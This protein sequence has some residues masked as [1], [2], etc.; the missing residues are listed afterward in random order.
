MKI[1]F[2]SLGL[3]VCG[4]VRTIFELANGL[5]DRGHDISITVFGK[6][7]EHKWF[8]RPINASIHYADLTFIQR[9]FRK[10]FLNDLDYDY[11]EALA[12]MIPDCDVNVATHSFTAY[13]TAL[14]DK[15]KLFY[16]VQNY[17]PW[18]YEGE[19]LQNKA[20]LSYD[21]PLTKLVVS[22]W[23]QDKVG[24]IFVGNGVNLN[25]FRSTCKKSDYPM[26]LR[27][28]RGIYWKGEDI[29][30]DAIINCL[31]H[32]DF[33]TLVI[34]GNFTET[35]LI[36][37]YSSASAL[38]CAPK[39]EGFGLYVL[40]A[41]A[42]GCPV[43]T[44]KCVGIEEYAEHLNNAY[45]VS[46]NDPNA[47]ASALAEVLTAKA[48]SSRLIQGGLKTAQRFSFDKVVGRVEKAFLEEV[49]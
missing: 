4:G 49:S 2:N 40:E 24:G 13:P 6:K 29:V 46:K 11:A 35:E 25:L 38:M 10:L 14:S 47:L 31:E 21:L 48:L 45:V 26:V 28:G 5:A 32:V 37:A 17:E 43:I 3:G 22:R 19:A 44:T 12:R 41:M 7:N 16:L 30:R 8:G 23:L 15:G 9:A 33:M 18:F 27:F 34:S 36:K 39:F 1:N 42:C 20:N